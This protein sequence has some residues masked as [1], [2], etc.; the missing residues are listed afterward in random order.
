MSG[1]HIKGQRRSMRNRVSIL[2]PIVGLF[3]W[4]SMVAQAPQRAR[5]TDALRQ[6]DASIE[7]LVQRVSPTVVQIIVT[8]YGSADQGNRSETSV[9]IGRQRAVGS[10]VIVDPEG[11]IVTK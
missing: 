4:A 11:Y 6:L 2:L 7:A 10:G 8:G 3:S 5:A 9:V 1:A